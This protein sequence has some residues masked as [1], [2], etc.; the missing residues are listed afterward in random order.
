MKILPL[1]IIIFLTACSSFKIYQ[2]VDELKD[3]NFIEINLPQ[4]L[5]MINLDV[6]KVDSIPGI[7]SK[8]ANEFFANT[9]IITK[10]SSQFFINNLNISNKL[11]P[12]TSATFFLKFSNAAVRNNIKLHFLENGLLNIND[13]NVYDEKEIVDKTMLNAISDDS[14]YDIF[15]FFITNQYLEK[16]DTI[17]QLVTI[18]TIKRIKTI[19]ETNLVPKSDHDIAKDLANDINLL[20][21]YYYDLIGGIPEIAYDDATFNTMI[22]EIKNLYNFYLS[23]F[24]GNVSKTNYHYSINILP[25]KNDEE[26]IFLFSF[27]SSKGFSY[28]ISDKVDNNYYLKITPLN[29]NPKIENYKISQHN[30]P[31]RKPMPCQITITNASGKNIIYKDTLKILQKGYIYYLPKKIKKAVFSNKDGELKYVEF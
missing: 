24:I 15:K 12:D 27:D 28:E 8:F 22:E 26:N 2:N 19:Y 5:L 11:I 18:D 25:N 20:K 17:N 10:K 30:L 16:T 6:Y 29:K 21:G 1:C 4:N 9:P 23:Y 14:S 3:Y 31:A 13:D 7:Y